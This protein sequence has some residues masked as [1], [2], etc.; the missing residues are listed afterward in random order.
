MGKPGL[1]LYLFTITL[2]VSTYIQQVHINTQVCT[3]RAVRVRSVCIRVI[4]VVRVIRVI[5]V[6]RVGPCFRVNPCG[7]M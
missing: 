2:R 4:H 5:R 7:S 3:I 6:I 1:A